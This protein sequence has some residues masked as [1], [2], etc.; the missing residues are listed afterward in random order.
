M[1]LSKKRLN[2]R[3]Y[4]ILDNKG[5]YSGKIKVLYDDSDK[6]RAEG[7]IEKGLKSGEW[8]HYYENRNIEKIENYKFGELNGVR[9]RFYE[10]GELKYE[11]PTKNGKFFGDY[12]QYE[13]DGTISYKCFL[14]D[15]IKNGEEIF[16][17]E[18]G[19]ETY[20]TRYVNGK[21][22]KIK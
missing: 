15:D 11:C 8:K 13:K 21:E 10:T 1:G 3:N 16:Y 2:G 9:M 7:Q 22:I 20:R 6:V 12:I 19:N 4:Y 17:D 18:E 14:R 5:Y